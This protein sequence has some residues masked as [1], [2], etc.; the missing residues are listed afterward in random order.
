MQLKFFFFL[1]LFLSED[2]IAQLDTS[3]RFPAPFNFEL[4]KSQP[5][6]YFVGDSLP[7]H[8]HCNKELDSMLDLNK[9]YD[10]QF[11]LWTKGFWCI[12][13]FVLT[14]K[15]QTWEARYFDEFNLL[16]KELRTSKKQRVRE[17]KVDQSMIRQL[18]WILQNND[19]LTLPDQRLLSD[20]LSTYH[21]DTTDF[22]TYQTHSLRTD[23]VV[24][25]FEL[26]NSIKSRCYSYYSPESY[27]KEYNVK[28][29]AQV[30]TN[31]KLIEK[32][33]AINI[34]NN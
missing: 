32:F 10:F 29:L 2:A 24:Y 14:Y 4:D 8:V 17:R 7:K 28:E 23:G 15:N 34:K 33:L 11:R 13:A 20:R 26:I 5:N 25:T 19:I 30:I 12:S 3:Y 21:I 6:I 31:V 16:T 1:L 22:F 18:W 9:D 27:F